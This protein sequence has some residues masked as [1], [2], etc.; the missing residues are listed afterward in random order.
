MSED[1]KTAVDSMAKAFEEFKATN[2]ERLAEIEKK[3]L[4]DPLVEEKLK[5]IEADLDRF[6]DINQKLT[7][8]Q[9]EQK[10]FGE[11]LDNMEAMLKRP[12]TGLEAKE[13]DFSVKA[14]DK[15]LRKGQD[16]MEPD[17]VKALTVNN[18]TGAGF[19]APPEYVNE[20]IKTITEIS[21][22]RTIARVRA[23][24]QKSIQMPST[25]TFSVMGS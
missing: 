21:P 23:T 9:E 15:F 16:K 6:E 17:E 1:V 20:L 19:L 22:L 10:Q 4:S 24:S 18:D 8:A 5:N 2:D 13:I 7:L 14:F 3:G 12:E 25:A 11:K